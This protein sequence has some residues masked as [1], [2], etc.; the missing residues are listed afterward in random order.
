M[1]F[2]RKCYELES[3]FKAKQTTL[4]F[5]SESHLT[6]SRRIVPIILEPVSYVHTIIGNM[7]DYMPR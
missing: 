5:R 2:T 4:L 1:T 7:K 6:E 3:N